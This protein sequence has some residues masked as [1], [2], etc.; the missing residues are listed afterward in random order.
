M[1][2]I[3]TILLLLALAVP[4][5]AGDLTGRSQAFKDLFN[6]ETW[7]K[8][9][10]NRDRAVWVASATDDSAAA[11]TGL[12]LGTVSVIISNRIRYKAPATVSLGTGTPGNVVGS[13][14]LYTSC[15]YVI[16]MAND[17]TY[18]VTKGTNGTGATAVAAKNAAALPTLA[19]GVAPVAAVIVTVD[20]RGA[21]AMTWTAG[22]SLTTTSEVVALVGGY[23][24]NQLT[25]SPVNE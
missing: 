2:Y 19:S 12:I 9:H 7:V 1:K 15:P 18:S 22:T 8:N 16:G 17:G 21:G 11:A 24:V 4:A 20:P 5:Q 13:T 3:V 6:F 10:A 14:T 25:L 23:D